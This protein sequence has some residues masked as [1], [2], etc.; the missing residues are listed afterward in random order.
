MLP[1][2]I[3]AN[4]VASELR[5]SQSGESAAARSDAACAR[6]NPAGAPGDLKP[7]KT[8]VVICSGPL[9]DP[10]SEQFWMLGKALAKDGHRV[11]LVIGRKRNDLA[12]KWEGCDVHVWHSSAPWGPL[13]YFK[14]LKICL[15]VRPHAVIAS[16]QSN[17]IAMPIGLMC[18]VPCRIAWHRSLSNQTPLDYRRWN[19]IRPLL[20]SFKARIF[21]MATHVVPVS[22]A[23][24]R[25]AIIHYGVEPERCK[26]VFHTCRPD[27]RRVVT[28]LPK[29]HDAHIKQIINLGRLVPSKGV[30]TLLHAMK[31]VKDRNPQWTIHLTH[32]GDGP[33]L[34]QLQQLAAD[35]GLTEQVHFLGFMPQ[36]KAFPQ[37]IAADVM[38]LPIRSDPGPGVIPEGLG[39]GIPVITCA[40]GGIGELVRGTE[41][42]KLI[43]SDDPEALAAAL[44]EVLSNPELAKR[45]SIAGREL[46]EKKFHLDHWVNSVKTWMEKQVLAP[47]MKV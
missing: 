3:N 47:Y 14:F 42:V 24:M 6:E 2:P 26:T 27:P 21:N 45:M 46:F 37:A 9:D 18:D 30:D 43:P 25:D 8:S 15:K 33:A 38:A 16:F 28:E 31:L 17:N 41:A 19:L 44:Q 29:K 32:V 1:T 13:D 22:P 40:V 39:L 4:F 34:P 35:L 7:G 20:E 12:G 23:G 11:T 36:Q 5:D 10:Q